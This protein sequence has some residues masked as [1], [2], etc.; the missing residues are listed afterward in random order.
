MI[1]TRVSITLSAWKRL[2]GGNVRKRICAALFVLY[3][4][5]P[6]PPPPPPS[7]RERLLVITLACFK[8]I[9]AGYQLDYSTWLNAYTRAAPYPLMPGQEAPSTTGNLAFAAADD[10]YRFQLVS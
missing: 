10:I 3:P 4:P 6:S 9:S 1:V 8:D 7:R 5:P 2:R